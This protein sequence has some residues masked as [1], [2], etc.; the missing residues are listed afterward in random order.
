MLVSLFLLSP[1]YNSSTR[2]IL[3]QTDSVMSLCSMPNTRWIPNEHQ[4]KP[5]P[6][7]F[8]SSMSWLQ[9]TSLASSSKSLFHELHDPRRLCD[10]FLKY[11][12]HIP[13]LQ[14]CSHLPLPGR[15]ALHNLTPPSFRL[16]YFHDMTLRF[17]E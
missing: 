4:N 15:P 10:F 13:L 2:E 9:P 1:F 7:R 3:P 14:L 8:K 16:K 5:F 12:S 17:P 11:T 6:L